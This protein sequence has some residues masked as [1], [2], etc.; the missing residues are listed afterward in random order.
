[1][2]FRKSMQ[3]HSAKNFDIFSGWATFSILRALNK[4][5]L[6]KDLS[7]DVS[8]ECFSNFYLVSD[9]VRPMHKAF[10]SKHVCLYC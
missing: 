5:R 1:M 9:S 2:T 7:S 8:V 4:L 6:L 3:R 10:I